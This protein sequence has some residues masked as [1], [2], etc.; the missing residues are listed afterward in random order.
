[1]NSTDQRERQRLRSHSIGSALEGDGDAASI[2][3]AYQTLARRYL[4][5]RPRFTHLSGYATRADR[6]E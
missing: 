3:M 5:P 1:M 2:L 6:A 4:D